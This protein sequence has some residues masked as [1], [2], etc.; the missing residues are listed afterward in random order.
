MANPDHGFGDSIKGSLEPA[1]VLLAVLVLLTIPLGAVDLSGPD[2]AE[3]GS[4]EAIA[5]FTT[6]PRFVSPWV[7]YVPEVDGVPSP[8]DFLDVSSARPAS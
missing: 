6:D 7:A 5:R 2:T 1:V 8:T 4:V 3:S